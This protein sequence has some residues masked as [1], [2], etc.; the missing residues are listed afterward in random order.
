MGV[1][2]PLLAIRRESSRK[3]KHPSGAHEGD[4]ALRVPNESVA[5]GKARR[6]DFA[7]WTEI[8]DAW[9]LRRPFRDGRTADFSVSSSR[10]GCVERHVGLLSKRSRLL[11]KFGGAREVPLPIG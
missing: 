9:E 6:H 8:L 2:V 3:P 7:H 5:G 11:Q 4:S 10:N 1:R